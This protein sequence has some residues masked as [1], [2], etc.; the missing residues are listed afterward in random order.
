MRKHRCQDILVLTRALALFICVLS[1]VA[2][3][4]QYGASYLTHLNI[5]SVGPFAPKSWQQVVA[6]KLQRD[7]E[8]IPVDLRLNNNV[9][10]RGKFAKP[11]TGDFIECLLDTHSLAITSL[12]VPDPAASMENGTLI[13]VEVA[14]L[15]VNVLPLQT[16]WL[17][18]SMAP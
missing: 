3:M 16:N 4:L 10:A 9:R 18:I 6:E 12:D 11:L 5:K 7:N 13:T 14:L 15:S 2:L 17:D 1:A 8:K